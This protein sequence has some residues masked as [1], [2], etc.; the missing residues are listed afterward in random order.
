MADWRRVVPKRKQNES[1]AGQRGDRQRES[2]EVTPTREQA[3]H[4][5]RE[6][7]IG[8]VTQEKGKQPTITLQDGSVVDAYLAVNEWNRLRDIVQPNAA[9]FLSLLALAQGRPGDADPRHFETLAAF[10]FLNE[11]DHAIA[12]LTRAVLLNSFALTNAGPI[13]VPLRLKSAVD[14]AVAEETRARLHQEDKEASARA[15]SPGDFLDQLW[16]RIQ[17]TEGQDRSSEESPPSR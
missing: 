16:D 5:E 13:I 7:S 17:R 3:T 8:T 6:P 2:R 14:K 4:A 11:R 9:E 15:H 10:S 1:Q 12:P